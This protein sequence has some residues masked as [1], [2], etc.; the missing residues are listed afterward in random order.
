[1]LSDFRN[2]IDC[3]FTETHV[4]RVY[5]DTGLCFNDLYT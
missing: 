1:M 2:V 4:L 5:I 3:I